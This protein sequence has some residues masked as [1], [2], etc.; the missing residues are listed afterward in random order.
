[1]ML[2]VLGMTNSMMF[3][4]QQIYPM[5]HPLSI[6]RYPVYPAQLQ[7]SQGDVMGT[8]VSVDDHLRN[9][10]M[11]TPVISTLPAAGPAHH[12]YSQHLPYNPYYHMIPQRS[13]LPPQ[14]RPF[15]LPTNPQH[16]SN[17]GN[18]VVRPI[19][20][21]TKQNG[22]SNSIL[23]PSSSNHLLTPPGS[24]V[25]DSLITVTSVMCSSHHSSPCVPLVGSSSS[26]QVLWMW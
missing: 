24:L 3:P 10:N 23:P 13:L 11:I 16:Q 22:I 17:Q 14:I 18:I 20:V 4:P 21:N 19:T 12:Q 1:M 2:F 5:P 7:Y 15:S 26:S 8:S 25:V 6:A 9:N